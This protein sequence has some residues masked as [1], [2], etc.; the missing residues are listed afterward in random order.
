MIDL[1]WHTDVVLISLLAFF[2]LLLLFFLNEY[3][4]LLDSTVGLDI[5][6]ISDSVKNTHVSLQAFNSTL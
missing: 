5:N 2:P 4:P 1:V 6:N 3:S